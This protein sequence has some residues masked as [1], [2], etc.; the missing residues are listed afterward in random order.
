MRRVKGPPDQG[1]LAGTVDAA[2][3]QRD[4][5]QAALPRLPLDQPTVSPAT[6]PMQKHVA[7]LDKDHRGHRGGLTEPHRARISGLDQ[8]RK[9]EQGLGM[10]LLRLT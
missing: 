1:G 4:A 10:E 9:Q 6:A 5:S 7:I 2:D 3:C 8:A